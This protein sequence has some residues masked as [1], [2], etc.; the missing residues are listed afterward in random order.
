MYLVPLN[1][2]P[3]QTVSFNVDGAYWQL[4]IY[5]A[6]SHMC[7]DITRNGVVLIQGVRCFGGI[8]LIPYKYLE[9]V[10]GNFIFNDDA[11]WQLFGNG[12]N[13]TYLNADELSQYNELITQ[14]LLTWQP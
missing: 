7:C 3:N 2:T 5:S 13:L 9:G 12:V 8:P 1:N 6:I 11:D 4:Y 10:F 14:G